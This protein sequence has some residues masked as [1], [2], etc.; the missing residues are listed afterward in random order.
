MADPP[1]L[2]AFA[3]QVRVFGGWLLPAVE[4][5]LPFESCL[6]CNSQLYRGRREGCASPDACPAACVLVQGGG[7]HIPA[8]SKVTGAVDGAFDCGY[9]VTINVAGQVGGWPWR[10]AAGRRRS[11]VLAECRHAT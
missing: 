5:C 8:G 6:P 7:A 1:A 10:G 2:V 11:V 9:F 3:S 4:G